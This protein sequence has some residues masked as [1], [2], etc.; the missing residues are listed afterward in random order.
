MT[1]SLV[2]FEFTPFGWRV[3]HALVLPEDNPIASPLAMH[4]C[5]LLSLCGNF[6]RKLRRGTWCKRPHKELA[7]A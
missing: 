4:T 3:V 2:I 5:G 6:N 1:P 7:H